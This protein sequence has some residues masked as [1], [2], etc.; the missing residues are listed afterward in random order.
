MYLQTAVL[1]FYKY[2]FK[3]NLCLPFAS[4]KCCFFNFYVRFQW[5]IRSFQLNISW[6][7]DKTNKNSM[8]YAAWAHALKLSTCLSGEV[9]L[10]MILRTGLMQIYGQIY[11]V[12]TF[13]PLW[14]VF[15][16]IKLN[17]SQYLRTSDKALVW[18]YPTL[19]R[20][21]T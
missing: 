21:W 18:P 12:N 1:A 2:P 20:E 6:I 13:E 3:N 5:F 11:K 10:S 14:W 7:I 9:Y 19:N 16:E 4:K 17:L 8:L 15:T